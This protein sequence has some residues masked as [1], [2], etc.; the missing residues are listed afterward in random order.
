MK[1]ILSVFCFTLFFT[2]VY[3]AA[4]FAKP[5]T[6]AVAPFTISSESGFDFLKT[7]IIDIFSSR[8]TFENKVVVVDK[9]KVIEI[10]KGLE[11]ITEK[12]AIEKAKALGVDYLV[13]G[14]LEESPKGINVESFVVSTNPND[15]MLSFSEKSSKYESADVI[16]LIVNRISTNIKKDILKL[17]IPAV[18]KKEPVADSGN[19]YAHPDTF[20]KDIGV[21]VEKEED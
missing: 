8:L 11:K 16:M 14:N 12:I 3:A 19:I 10:F 1:K 13:F 20:L 7:G 9:V 2:V 5:V 4:S 18:K 15:K 17:N 6:L 21:E